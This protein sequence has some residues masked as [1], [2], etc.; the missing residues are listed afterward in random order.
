MIDILKIYQKYVSKNLSLEKLYRTLEK[1]TEDA[2]KLI[3]LIQNETSEE[4]MIVQ[5]ILWLNPEF[6]FY[7]NNYNSFINF[8]EQIINEYMHK[9]EII[10]LENNLFILKKG[11]YLI[12]IN[13][14]SIS[15]NIFLP[16]NYCQN[17][18]FCEN[19]NEE[20]FIDVSLE[21]PELSFYILRKI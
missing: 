9:I 11:K 19:C 2:I 3:K 20:F 10:H 8:L 7:F 6:H 17:H 15:Q 5:L 1:S 4:A 21:V 16:S 14:S 12:L 13:G 18:Y